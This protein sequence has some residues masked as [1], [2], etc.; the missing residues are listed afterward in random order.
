MGLINKLKRTF[1]S[2]LIHSAARFGKKAVHFAHAAVDY[3]EKKGLPIAEKVANTVNKVSKLA[4][5]FVAGLAPELLP[6][7][8]GVNKLSGVADKGLRNAERAIATAHKVINPLK[9]LA[10]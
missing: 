10:Q 2:K 1:G 8:Y 6:A 4:T 7:L 5:P 9:K 3:A